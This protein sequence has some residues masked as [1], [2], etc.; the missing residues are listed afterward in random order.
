M[1]FYDQDLKKIGDAVEGTFYCEENGML[2]YSSHTF[3]SH[4]ITVDPVKARSYLVD[5]ANEEFRME[6]IRNLRG[7]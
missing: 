2:I 5:L 6:Y 4:R 3:P 7:D 1:T